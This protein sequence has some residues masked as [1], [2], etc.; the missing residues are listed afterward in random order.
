MRLQP[1]ELVTLPCGTEFLGHAGKPLDSEE[2]DLGNGNW[3]RRL[4][5]SDLGLEM[6]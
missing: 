2:L 3:T 1:T 4:A 5:V 6:N